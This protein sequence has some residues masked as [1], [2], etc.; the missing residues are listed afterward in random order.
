MVFAHYRNS[1]DFN[2]VKALKLAEIASH[3]VRVPQLISKDFNCIQAV[4]RT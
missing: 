2:C 3:V 4:K 1:K